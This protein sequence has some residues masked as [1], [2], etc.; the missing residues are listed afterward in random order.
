MKHTHNKILSSIIVAAFIIVGFIAIITFLFVPANSS[1]ANVPL[2]TLVMII[3]LIIMWG[4]LLILM[5][6]NGYHDIIEDPMLILKN[7]Y[8]KGEISKKEF[9]DKIKDIK[10]KA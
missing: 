9:Q 8:A 2:V 7:R 5:S 3:L 1:Y 6:K 4:L 10:G